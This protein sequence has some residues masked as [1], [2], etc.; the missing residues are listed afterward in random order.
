[1]D[2]LCRETHH[3]D[4]HIGILWFGHRHPLVWGVNQPL[5]GD[6]KCRKIGCPTKNR[7]EDNPFSQHCRWKELKKQDAQSSIKIKHMTLVKTR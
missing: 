6:H 7:S 2:V 1:M 5:Y 3:Y 4:S